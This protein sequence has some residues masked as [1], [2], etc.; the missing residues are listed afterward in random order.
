MQGYISENWF[1]KKCSKLNSI[2][3]SIISLMS[4]HL[5]KVIL[6]PPHFFAIDIMEEGNTN[7]YE[8][9]SMTSECYSN[10]GIHR[11]YR[12]C[13]ISSG[14]EVRIVSF[15]SS[16]ISSIFHSQNLGR[17]SNT[18][19]GRTKREERHISTPI[20]FETHYLLPP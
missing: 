20:Q 4:F 2:K 5:N 16:K 12:R 11:N 13:E 3:I 19:S 18:K 17:V 14:S 6:S 8:R 1:L 15:K 7:I 10:Q 9:C